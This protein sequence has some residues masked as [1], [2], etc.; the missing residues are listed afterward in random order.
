MHAGGILIRR[1]GHE[2]RC[3]MPEGRHDRGEEPKSYAT[4]ARLRG[5]DII[6]LLDRRGP[7]DRNLPAG[8]AVEGRA[9]SVEESSDGRWHHHHRKPA[10]GDKKRG[11]SGNNNH[12][13]GRQPAS[14][15]SQHATAN[16][17]EDWGHTLSTMEQLRHKIAKMET[18]LLQQIRCKKLQLDEARAMARTLDQMQSEA[19]GY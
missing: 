6:L 18:T 13:P 8:K 7:T 4:K 3:V 9:F 19:A 10:R 14:A 15:G 11:R 12:R 5:G 16:P 1:A 2:D 17:S